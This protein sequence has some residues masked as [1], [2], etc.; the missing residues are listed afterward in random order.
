MQIVLYFHSAPVMPGPSDLAPEGALQ[1][2]F[3]EAPEGSVITE[4]EPPAL[5]TR[6]VRTQPGRDSAF[7]HQ[8]PG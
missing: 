6:A 8:A 7:L 5:S 1:S 3:S 4:Q 2:D